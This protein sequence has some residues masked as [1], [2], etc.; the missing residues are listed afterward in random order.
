MKK[1]TFKISISFFML[2]LVFY[3]ASCSKDTRCDIQTEHESVLT[4]YSDSIRTYLYFPSDGECKMVYS[5]PEEVF[6]TLEECQDA[7][8]GWF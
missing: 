4:K 1:V 7:C 3:L 6:E 5:W 2:F 8:E